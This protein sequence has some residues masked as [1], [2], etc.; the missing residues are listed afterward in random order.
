[1]KVTI[2]DVAKAV[3]VSPSTVSRAL[4]DN[5]R[6]SPEVRARVKQAAQEMNF[7]PN[8]M[9]RGLVNRQTRI[10][11]VVFPEEVGLNLS[12]PF[13]PEVLQGIGHAAGKR[14]YQILLLTGAPGGSS[15]DICRQAVDAGYVS[16]LILLT[17]KDVPPVEYDV[18]VVTI[19]HPVDAESRCYVDNDNVNAGYAAA[20]HLLAK[21]HR[22]ILLVG[23]A[24]SVM[25]TADRRKG[26]EKAL[27]EVSLTLPE[28]WVLPGADDIIALDAILAQP[29]PPTA[30]VCMDD[31][32]AIRLSQLLTASGRSVPG[33]LSLISFNNNEASRYHVPALTTFDVGS[34]QLGANA[35][36]L[37]L[38]MLDGTITE[39]TAI[40]VPF[41]LIER[42]SVADL[43]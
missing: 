20:S 40:D 31:L 14:R 43:K 4:H 10:I 36:N 24:G 35:M 7:H 30:A 1:M 27:A 17:A 41:T 15:Q 21:G 11:G 16:G 12:N 23:Y 6:I 33:D 38:D 25:F 29:N 18:P 2:K 39:P 8:L 9:A 28:K 5:D 26:V 19:G 13:Y 42:E 34:Y 3:G 32:T 22:R 37:M